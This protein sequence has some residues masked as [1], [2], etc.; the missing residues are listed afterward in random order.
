ML[1]KKSLFEYY[2]FSWIAFKVLKGGLDS[3]NA[4]IEFEK[5]CVIKHMVNTGLDKNVNS[6]AAAFGFNHFQDHRQM[7]I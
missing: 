3:L 7:M 6:P 2:Y 4:L 1:F 5:P